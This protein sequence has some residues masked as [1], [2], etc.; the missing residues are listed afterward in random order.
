VVPLTEFDV[1]P[2]GLDYDRVPVTPDDDGVMEAG[3]D[4]RCDCGVC[5]SLLN[6]V[7]VN[8]RDDRSVLVTD[9]SEVTHEPLATEEDGLCDECRPHHPEGWSHWYI[10]DYGGKRWRWRV[11][12]T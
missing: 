3:I 5:D 6:G 4:L 2:P 1:R 8:E 10:A 12:V 9:G 11:R 7:T